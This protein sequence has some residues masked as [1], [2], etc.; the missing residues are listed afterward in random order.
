MLIRDVF[1][2]IPRKKSAIFGKFLLS[3]EGSQQLNLQTFH[4]CKLHTLGF[5]TAPHGPQHLW[6]GLSA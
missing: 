4:S 1:L 2:V 6:K 3:G 5:D